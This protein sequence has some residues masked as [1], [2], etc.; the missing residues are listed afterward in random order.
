MTLTLISVGQGSVCV[1]SDWFRQDT[2][3]HATDGDAAT[4]II[5]RAGCTEGDCDQSH[6]RVGTADR[7]SCGETLRSYTTAHSTTYTP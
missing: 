4:E 1:C 6:Q 5:I 2:G 7:A 3:F